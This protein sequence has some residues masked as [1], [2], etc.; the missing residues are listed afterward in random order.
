MK[1]ARRVYPHQNYHIF[2]FLGLYR[3]SVALNYIFLV[4]LLLL[5]FSFCL[6]FHQLYQNKFRNTFMSVLF[7]IFSASLFC[8]LH[9]HSVLKNSQT[10]SFHVICSFPFSIFFYSANL[11]TWMVGFFTMSHIWEMTKR[12]PLSD[13]PVFS[14]VFL[15]ML[16]FVYISLSRL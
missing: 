6:A 1:G 4:F 12:I 11:V 7:Q 3:S 16:L 2:R 9:F 13:A 15:F 8:S 14:K 10:L 5:Q